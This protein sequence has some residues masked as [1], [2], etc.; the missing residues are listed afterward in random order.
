MKAI[1]II[2]AGGNN[3]K[4]GELTKIRALS[5]IPVG[6]CYRTLDFTLSNM[7]NSGVNKVAVITQYNSRSLH[8][9][10]SSSKWWDFGRKHGGLFVFS[11]YLSNDNSFWYRGTA[12]SIYQ[13]MTFLKRSIE[14][15]VI[16]GSG[17]TVYKMD[18]DKLLQEHANSGADITVVYKDVED[19]D[20]RNYGTI[21]LDETGRMID[22]EEKPIDQ[23]ATKISM[24]IYVIQRTLLIKLLEAIIP[25]ERYDLVK[26]VIIRYRKKLKIMGYK[27]EGYWRAVNSIDTYFKTN[28]E[29]LNK[30]VRRLLIKDAPHIA[31]K[32]KD[33]PPAKYNAGAEVRDALI[34]S[35]SILN[36]YI[37]H[38]VLFRKV[39]TGEHSCIRNSVIMEGC[40][41]GNHCVI[42][43]AILDKEVV[44][45]DGKQVIGTPEN[46]VIISK[47]TVV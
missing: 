16:I 34:G 3:E 35:G 30:D 42:E 25:E 8:D 33:E 20:V 14:P 39:Y 23:I 21:E 4:L 7:S 36:G 11:P 5:A 47:G 44:L 6:S 46:P 32:P 24:G 9:H 12:D 27:F 37:D 19:E 28:M 31:T 2:L 41:I 18:Y 26:D 22:L 38:S 40:Y 13:N 43:N 17:N 15:Y 29:F 45:S 1:G 10:L